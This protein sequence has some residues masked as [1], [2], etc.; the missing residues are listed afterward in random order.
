MAAVHP[1]AIVD[2]KALL[3]DGVV[4]GPYACV[5]PDVELADG[6]ELGAHVVV[7]GHTR[8]GAG[9][10]VF[11]HACLGGDPQHLD[12]AGEPTRLELGRDNVIREHVTLHVGTV[13]GGGCTRIGDANLFMNASHV[14]HD[15][16][17]GS[18]VVMASFCG[19]AGHVTV[20]D[21]AVLGAY[22]GVHQQAR[23]GESAMTAAGSMVSLDVPPFA[24]VAGDRARMVGLNTV[25]LERRGFSADTVAAI[26][27][28]HRI[29]FRSRIVLAEEE[30]RGN[31]GIGTIGTSGW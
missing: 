13:R 27:Q 29:V 6:V 9:T 1:T 28:A 24:L 23:V 26:E 17:V 3:A 15:C 2:A 5:G 4:V 11:A 20:Q 12:Y 21:H 16:V 30:L 8:I 7:T 14:G 22:T 10:R 19:L 31:G 18:H 25:G